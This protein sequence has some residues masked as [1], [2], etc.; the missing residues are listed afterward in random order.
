[1]KTLFED[2]FHRN[3]FII[4]QLNL[5]L[6]CQQ[7]TKFSHEVSSSC[8]LLIIKLT[9]GQRILMKS[10]I[11]GADLSQMGNVMWHQ[12]LASIA[13]IYRSRA[14]MPLL[15]FELSLLLHALL[16][17]VGFCCI[18]HSGDSQF[19]TFKGLWPWPWIGSYCIPSC[20]IHRPQPTHQISL[21]SKK[22][23]VDGGMYGHLI[24]TLLGRLRGV[25]SKS[26]LS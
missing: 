15:S 4:P 11:T 21:K 16:T 22:V 17:I 10:R 26:V 24:P 14:V 7:L 12:A 18:H 9:T 5:N 6:S 20:I 3:N 2:A 23:F 19:P 8:L 25:E 13:A 1:M